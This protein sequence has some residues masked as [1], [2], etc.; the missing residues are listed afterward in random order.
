M[1]YIILLVALPTPGYSY[2]PPPA[3]FMCPSLSP[4]CA[5]CGAVVEEVGL[6]AVLLGG[7]VC[8]EHEGSGGCHKHT[9]SGGSAPTLEPTLSP[10]GSSDSC[11]DIASALR[12]SSSSTLSNMLASSPCA[13]MAEV[14][15]G[16]EACTHEGQ[17]TARYPNRAHRQAGTR[18]SPNRQRASVAGAL[19]S[20]LRQRPTCGSCCG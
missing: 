8:A 9:H 20:P 1:K 4:A 10:C 16:C 11:M 14:K 3:A 6:G 12:S 2:S 18:L 19:R 15:G 7:V 17:A 13:G 5:R